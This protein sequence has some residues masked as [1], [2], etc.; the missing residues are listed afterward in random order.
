M[1]TIQVNI[2][3]ED[4]TNLI[5]GTSPSYE[6]MEDPII[7]QL[8]E[9]TGGFRDDWSWY[10]IGFQKFSLSQLWHTYCKLKEK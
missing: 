7:K 4:L 6:L 5:K 8:G 1:T 3:I 10:N 2:D 9:Y